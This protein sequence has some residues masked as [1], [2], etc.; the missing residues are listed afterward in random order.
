MRCFQAGCGESGTQETWERMRS[1]RDLGKAT[2][3]NRRRVQEFHV[4]RSRAGRLSVIGGTT[5][6]MVSFQPVW[7]TDLKT[8]GARIARQKCHAMQLNAFIE[9]SRRSVAGPRTLSRGNSGGDS[10]GVP[11]SGQGL[12]S[13]PIWAGPGSAASRGGGIEK[14]QSGFRN[15]AGIRTPSRSQ[16]GCTTGNLSSRAIG[17]SGRFERVEEAPP[18]FPGSWIMGGGE[19]G[20]LV[21]TH[22]VVVPGRVAVQGSATAALTL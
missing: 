11:T 21:S 1:R 9:P 20:W 8:P 22:P 5:V 14:H 6:P 2:S 12:P 18:G 19:A 13:R 7:K 15:T 4:R 3:M 10:T 17:S 16:G